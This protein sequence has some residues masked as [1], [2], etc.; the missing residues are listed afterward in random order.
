MKKLTIQEKKRRGTYE[1]CKE[2][3][4]LSFDAL[5]QVPEPLME[6]SKVEQS[7]FDLCAN[8]MIHERT[9]TGAFIPALTRAASTYGIYC[10]ALEG[11]KQHGAYQVTQGGYS[12]K[13]GYSVVLNDCEKSLAAFERSMGLCLVSKSKLPPAPEIKRYGPFDELENP[14]HK[15]GMPI[16]PHEKDKFFT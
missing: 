9:L 1:R 3:K 16:D 6:L 7:Y 5:N 8:A 4:S 12:T 15:A 11:I 13:N 14:A 10:Q 2:R